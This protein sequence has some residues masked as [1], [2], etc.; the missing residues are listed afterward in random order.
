MLLISTL[1][2]SPYAAAFQ[3]PRL[4]LGLRAG[5][6]VAASRTAWRPAVLPSPAPARATLRRGSALQMAA[7]LG[8]VKQQIEQAL[9]GVDADPDDVEEMRA[10]LT[11]ATR[12]FERKLARE[13]KEPDVASYI[14]MLGVQY[15]EEGLLDSAQWAQISQAV[16]VGHASAGAPPLSVIREVN[17]RVD[18]GIGGLSLS[19]DDKE[20]AIAIV[21]TV[22]RSMA[23]KKKDTA[24]SAGLRGEVEAALY[25]R[26]VVEEGL[27]TADDWARAAGASPGAAAPA[28]PAPTAAPAAPAPAPAAAAGGGSGMLMPKRQVDPEILQELTKLFPNKSARDLTMA[29]A[30]AAGPLLEDAVF[31]VLSLEGPPANMDREAAGTDSQIRNIQTGYSG[32]SSPGAERA[33]ATATLLAPVTGEARRMTTPFVTTGACGFGLCF[34]VRTKDKAVTISKLFSASSP[35][36]NWGQGMAIKMSIYVTKDLRRSRGV[37]LDPPAWRLVGKSNSVE[38]PMVSWADGENAQ[39]GELPL[40]EPITIPA[41]SVMGFMLHS[42]DLYGLVQSVGVGGGGEMDVWGE[43]GEEEGQLPYVAGDVICEDECITLCAGLAIGHNAFQDLEGL[44]MPTA[45]GFTGH[46]DYVAE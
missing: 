28:A 23:R 30:A 31:Q 24:P 19:P 3:S 25:S 9:A 22:C 42:N 44:A 46:V 21:T 26:L 39:Y 29:A 45:G 43:G 11:T 36:L 37:E 17:E 40:Q 34:D 7:D 32:D 27:L 14:S 10:I 20:E 2:C 13:G 35:G 38:L 33:A 4:L 41:N 16:E 15:V 1:A 6:H 12:S 18:A 8:A 5:R